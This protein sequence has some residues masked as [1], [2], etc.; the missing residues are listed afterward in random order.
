MLGVIVNVGA[1]I[2]GALLGLLFR[3]GIPERVSEAVMFA[4]GLCSLFVGIA[5]LSGDANAIVI[6]VSMVLGTIVGTLLNIDGGVNKLGQFIEKKMKGRGDGNIVEGFMTASLLFCV[7]AMAIIGSMNSGLL[8]D[9]QVLFTKSVMDMIS[10]CM[11]ASAL[12][13][14]VIFSAASVLVYQGAIV[15][16]AQLLRSVLTDEVLILN[17]TC[18]GSIMIIAIGLNLLGITKL[19]VADQLPAL[20]FVPLIFRLMALLPV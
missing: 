4:M 9:H 15:L 1:V 10:A 2:V 19:K 13:I 17:L 5:G 3:K 20:L 11:L 14:G 6:I 8:G 12:G 16:L 7:G 18:T